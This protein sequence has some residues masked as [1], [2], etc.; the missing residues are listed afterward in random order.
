ML[1]VIGVV[2][3]PQLAV[4]P[5]LD[6]QIVGIGDFVRCRDARPERTE[7]IE[8]FAQPGPAAPGRTTFAT[9]GDVHHAGVAEDR[10]APVSLLDAS[11]GAFDDDAQLGF[12]HEHPRYGVFRQAYGVAWSNDCVRVFEAH[13]D[14]CDLAR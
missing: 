11:G 1:H 7:G 8:R 13:R 9:T 14:R 5:E 3:M 2:V 12:M 10:A 6:P 4:V